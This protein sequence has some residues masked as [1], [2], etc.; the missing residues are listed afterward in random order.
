MGLRT[1]R[2]QK[3][4]AFAFGAALGAIATPPA[5][6]AQDGEEVILDPEL[7]D[8]APSSSGSAGGQAASGGE[9]HGWGDVLQQ[10]DATG[11]RQSTLEAKSRPEDDYDPTANT[12]IARLEM[13]GQVAADLRQEGALEDAF[14]TRLRFGGEV[15]FR[16]SRN[17]RLV[18]GSRLDFFWA[19]PGPNDDVIK[20]AGRSALDEDRFEVDIFAT[21][22]YVDTTLGDGVHLRVGQQVVSLGRMD[23]YSPTDMLAVFDMRPQPRLDMAANK[24]AQPAV[25]LDWDLN[26]RATIQAVYVPWFMP[27]LSRG[28]RDQYVSKVMTGTGTGQTP[29]AV[30][31]LVD[32][33]Q[34]TKIGESALRFV[35]PSPDFKTP[36]AQVRANFRGDAMEFGLSF[37][38]ALEKLPSIYHTPMVNRVMV[39]PPPNRDIDPTGDASYR[40][41]ESDLGY[42]LYGGQSVVDVA[43]HRYNLIGLDGSIDLAPVSLGFEFAF[44]P[45]RHLVTGSTR[46]D[47][48]YLPL[49]NVTE[50]L[51]DPLPPASGEEDA[52]G[53]L[54]PWTP[55]NVT[56]KR[57]RKGVPL[58]QA[59]MHLEWLKG[60]T[61]AL[62]GEIFWMNALALPHDRGRDWLGF[63]PGT[64]A[65]VGGMV[66]MSYM[67]WD[68]RL[69]L[70]L[71]TVA[72]VGPSL[73]LIPH[74]EVKASEGLYVDVGAQ[75]F[76][77]ANPGFNGMQKMNIGGAMSGYDQ[78]FVGLRWLP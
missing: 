21:A 15:E 28:N 50:Q 56:D 22:A 75:I 49:P 38:T 19:V 31:A 32:P 48:K 30:R 24:L 37:G 54:P 46:S 64:G 9:D 3:L 68:G 8:S 63:I 59:A 44:S 55:S 77:G 72:M 34:Q 61:F 53:N 26:S 33:S 71:T 29:E 36:Q 57:I 10:P 14:E 5:A 74:A 17:L 78:V 45:S 25:R 73:V 16:R 76:E 39:G 27:H 12:G 62:V 11:P 35:G 69:R 4:A 52:D 18:L 70:D 2:G 42:S 66:A 41:A 13:L 47:G 67:A 60:E 1:G 20:A 40:K 51:T 7:M 58:I 65:F 6:S 43:Y 23:M